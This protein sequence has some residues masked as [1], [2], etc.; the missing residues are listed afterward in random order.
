MREDILL[1]TVEVLNPILGIFEEGDILTETIDPNHMNL[2]IAKMS[3]RRQ[4]NLILD[5][6]H[7]LLETTS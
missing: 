6:S 4:L 3:S 7:A 1:E 5:I 2:L